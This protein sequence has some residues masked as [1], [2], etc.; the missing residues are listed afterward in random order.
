MADQKILLGNV[1]GEQGPAGP[2]TVS[3]STTTSGFENG[4]VLFNN[5]GKVG[6]K[7]LTASD[8]G[9]LPT[10][11]TAQTARALKGAGNA[12][13]MDFQ[14]YQWQCLDSSLLPY[15]YTMWSQ[16]NPDANHFLMTAHQMVGEGVVK[17][18]VHGLQ[19][20]NVQK[21]YPASQ[22]QCI[23][24]EGIPYGYHLKSTYQ[25]DAYFH[26]EVFSDEN[27]A[28]EKTY[29]DGAGQIAS[30][31]SIRYKEDLRPVEDAQ[32]E[33]MLDLQVIN[34]RYGAQAPD[35]VRDEKR[36]FG[37]I[38]EQVVKVMPDSVTLDREGLPAAVV[39]SDFIPLLLAQLKR[40]Q[41]QMDALE[42]RI[43]QLEEGNR[44]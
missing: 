26:L 18:A 33:A 30:A 3:S 25:S 38:A 15:G 6:A 28:R 13:N 7:K 21:V 19:G 37:M 16:W 35:H 36:H 9:A 39:Y 17:T 41:K 1:R 10:S 44:E 5:N 34:F 23:A 8:V 24:M 4:Q 2:N 14:A 43:R 31:S 20:E 27:S 29:T 42:Q 11:G 12:S 40:Q 22:L 32:L